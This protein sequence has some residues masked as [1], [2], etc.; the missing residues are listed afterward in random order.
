[1][2]FEFIALDLVKKLSGFVTFWMIC[3]VGKNPVSQVM[4]HCDSQAA[5]GRANSGFYNGKYRHIRRRHDTVKQLIS[6]G[7]ISIEYVKSID[8]LVDPLTKSLPPPVQMYKLLEGMRV[9]STN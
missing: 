1:M 2:E 8:N 9:K 3:H 7:V 5:I 6:S 4:I